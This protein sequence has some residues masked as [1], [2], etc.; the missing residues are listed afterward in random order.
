M[1]TKCYIITKFHGQ[2]RNFVGDWF[3]KD[4]VRIIESIA[5]QVTK[6]VE[7]ESKAD[8]LKKK[9][10]DPKLPSL[11]INSFTYKI[12]KISDFKVE[13]IIQCG[14]DTAP[15]AFFVDQGHLFR[16]G[17]RTFEGHHFMKAGFNKG[18]E[19]Q[20]TIIEKEFRKAGYSIF[21]R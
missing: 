20:Q 8:Y 21:A 14:G 11:I 17:K 5:V 4:I 19:L 16:G 15:Y 10:A 9:I 1:T 12:N 3:I 7:D 18:L 2:K 13:G 6:I